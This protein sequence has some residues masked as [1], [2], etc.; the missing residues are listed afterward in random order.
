[1]RVAYAQAGGCRTRYLTEGKGPA[2]LLLHPIGHSADVFFRNVDALASAFTVI[3]PDLPGHGFSDPIAFDS[4]PPQGPTVAHL[5]A[6]LT[7]LGHDSFAVLGSSYGGLLAALLA[8]AEPGRTFG[9]VIVGSGSVFHE[10]DQQRTTLSGTRDNVADGM[11]DPSI[12][13]CRKRIA[14]IC[15][16][17]DSVPEEILLSRATS[18]ALPDRLPNFLDTLDG[19]AASGPVD[20]ILDRL[21]KLCTPTLVITGRDDIR[22]SV[23]RHELGVARMP[24]ARL[25]VYE[26]CGHLPSLEHADRFNAEVLSF[27]GP[28]SRPV[29]RS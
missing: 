16:S 26:R 17:P 20:R 3:A 4:K 9:L 15:F 5:R 6:L 24:D 19:L 28:L 13:N 29:P 21:E 11:R 10:N 14:N 22:A 12:A 23:E 7:G 27:L 18:L 25:T 2:L 8:E 1:M